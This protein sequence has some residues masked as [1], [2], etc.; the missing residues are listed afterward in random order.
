MSKEKN[1]LRLSFKFV[2][3][4]FQLNVQPKQ[5]ILSLYTTL[6][7]AYSKPNKNDDKNN[8]KNKNNIQT[9]AT[10]FTDL[11]FFRIADYFIFLKPER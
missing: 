3:Y 5:E 9:F 11:I 4:W 8:N 10:D 2:F 1:V 6:L 7:I